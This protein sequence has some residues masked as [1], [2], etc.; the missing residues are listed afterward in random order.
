M[1]PL[2]AALS[3]VVSSARESSDAEVR[4]VA[5]SY[6]RALTGSGDDRAREL[7]LGGVSMDAEIFT[8][9]SARVVS[10]EPVRQEE[11]DLGTVA[12]LMRDLDQEGRLARAKLL[13]TDTHASGM[14]VMALSPVSYTHL[15]LPTICSV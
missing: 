15:T 4:A 9:D 2:V 6:L 13:N 11:G 8:L 3:L 14:A 1:L 7:L 5:D 12:K 10:R